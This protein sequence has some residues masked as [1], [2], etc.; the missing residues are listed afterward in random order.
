MKKYLCDYPVPLVSDV[1]AY[2]R[3]IETQSPIVSTSHSYLHAMVNKH[4]DV[5]HD[6][7]K[8]YFDGE[9]AMAGKRS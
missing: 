6:A 9:K 2:V 3:A 7:V 5:F 8:A 4:G 1:C